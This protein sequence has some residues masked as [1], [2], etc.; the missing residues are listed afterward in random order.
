[1]NDFDIR[2]CIKFLTCMGSLPQLDS[3]EAGAV[4]GV[5]DQSGYR[6]YITAINHKSGAPGIPK[7]VLSAT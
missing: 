5:L 6:W 1:M 2:L 4:S 3:D 7:R